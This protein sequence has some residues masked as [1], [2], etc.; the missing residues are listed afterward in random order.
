MSKGKRVS[1]QQIETILT[2]HKHRANAG[3]KPNERPPNLNRVNVAELSRLPLTAKEIAQTLGISASSVHNHLYKLGM[4]ICHVCRLR[5][6]KKQR[7]V[8][9]K[10]FKTMKQLHGHGRNAS[11][12]I[13]C[14]GPVTDTESNNITPEHWEKHRKA[15]NKYRRNNAA[16]NRRITR[17]CN[18]KVKVKV[19]KAYGSKCQAKKFKLSNPDTCSGRMELIHVN[20]DGH[21]HR[22]AMG[23]NLGGAA[24]Y[25]FV[26][27]VIANGSK[28]DSIG[29]VWHK[30]DFGFL[31]M[32]HHKEYDSETQRER[33]QELWQNPDFRERC[34]AASKAGI[35][36]KEANNHDQTISGS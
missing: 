26:R 11:K 30:K 36:K 31:C 34:I 32:S 18:L 25:K 27:D 21:E 29:K 4:S 8:R 7:C 22:R 17:D 33:M 2:L 19:F 28:K 24:M 16:L 5:G 1:P 15:I 12:H 35:A 6:D 14:C 20:Q 3:L 10:K 23:T 9:C 13:V